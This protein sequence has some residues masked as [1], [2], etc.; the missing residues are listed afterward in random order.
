MAT[1]QILSTGSTIFYETEVSDDSKNS[2]NAPTTKAVYDAL[3]SVSGD[4][5]EVETTVTEGS[6]KVPTS[7]AV[8]T[9]IAAVEGEIPTVPTEAEIKA[10]VYD[11]IY[12]SAN[13]KTY[14]VTIDAEGALSVAEVTEGE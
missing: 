1:K 13:D 2:L 10:Y 11:T 5:P 12:M 14:A 9:A 7:G 6:T 3:G 4:I 8:Y